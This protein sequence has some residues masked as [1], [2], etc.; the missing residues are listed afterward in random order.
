MQ[1]LGHSYAAAHSQFFRARCRARDSLRGSG[2]ETCLFS[3]RT[4]SGRRKMN[5]EFPQTVCASS[6]SLFASAPVTRC[7]GSL[8]RRCDG[9]PSSSLSDVRTEGDLF[10]DLSPLNTQA[11][12]TGA[13]SQSDGAG[14]QSAKGAQRPRR[15]LKA[16]TS[17]DG[18]KNA[19]LA[20]SGL[21]KDSRRRSDSHSA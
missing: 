4:T 15:H 11:R 13:S 21:V 5:C 17:S 2:H 8:P 10:S 3:N 20:I 9:G 16:L 19:V 14:L 6:R 12:K 7:K 1:D 18:S